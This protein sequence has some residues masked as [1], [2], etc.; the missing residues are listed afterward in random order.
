MSVSLISCAEQELDDMGSRISVSLSLEKHGFDNST[1]KTYL[2]GERVCWGTTSADK[3]VYVFDSNGA[4]NV[5]TRTSPVNTGPV[6][7]FVGTVTSGATPLYVLWSGK[8]QSYDQSIITGDVI[9]GTSLAVMNP[10]NISNTNSFANNA[11]ISVM[12]YNADCLQN[13]FGNI[14]S[15]TDV[16][17]PADNGSLQNVFGYIRYT[18]PQGTDGC[19][20]IKSVT[21]SA[22]E[23]LSGQ[24]QIDCSGSEPEV[25][26]IASPNTSLT[27]NT[28]YKS[29][30][31]YEAGTVYAVLPPGTYHNL[32]MTITPFV[33]GA[34]QQDASTGVPFTIEATEDVVV[35]RSKYTDAGTLPYENPNPN[36]E[37]PEDIWPNDTDAFDYGVIETKE[38]DISDAETYTLQTIDKVTYGAGLGFYTDKFAMNRVNEWETI[39][40]IQ[41]PKDS[42]ISFK[43]NK[44]GTLSFIPRVQ[45]VDTHPAIVVGLLTDSNG[46][47]S[48]RQIFNTTL[49]LTNTIKDEAARLTIPVSEEYMADITESA[50]VYV[51]SEQGSLLVYP[52][53]WSVD[54][55]STFNV[56]P[57]ASIMKTSVL[58]SENTIIPATYTKGNCYYISNSGNDDNTGLNSSSPIKTIAKL[59]TLPLS[60]GDAVLFKR[61]DMWRREVVDGSVMI[62]TK[63][64]VTYS[65]YGT[66]DKPI[67]NGSP[68]NGAV[69]GSWAVTSKANVY[70]YS[71]T[72]GAE[73]GGIF[74]NGTHESA[75]KRVSSTS[76]PFDW[77]DLSMDKDF[78]QQDG[79]IYFCSTVGNPTQRFTSMEFNVFGN[80]IEGTDNVT[81]DNLCLR[82][83]GSHGIN[84]WATEGMNIINCEIGLIGGAYWLG[85]PEGE[86]VRYGNGIQLYGSCG[87]FNVQNC[88]IYQCFD[89]GLTHQLSD[90]Q[91]MACVMENVKYRGNLIE[92]CTWSIEWFRYQLSGV[93]RIM[94]NVLIECNICR[95]A[96]YGW[97]QQRPDVDN[98][99]RHI[100]TWRADNPSDNFVIRNNIFECSTGELFQIHALQDE[101]LPVFESNNI[102]I[103]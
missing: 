70:V 102:C 3:V 38:A 45:N 1:T 24:I 22:D 9:S 8:S 32:K 76:M 92:N 55:S 64:G 78:F 77:T 93:E 15:E 101:W 6:A 18:I 43:I 68:Y 99:A 19:A 47:K 85:S 31:G 17:A 27:V 34:T 89:T 60:P 12:K 54:M 7:Q 29:G 62:P 71:H 30:L 49:Y 98:P 74:L 37:I 61:G 87:Y 96:G 48:Y 50:T 4:K 20:T 59:N 69:D 51:Y 14:T 66:G 13:V 53:K 72:F 58:S 42:Y 56:T 88:W 86:P 28:R 36:W 79:K 25:D 91:T 35:T 40:G 52:I 67:L 84:T 21:F 46:E 10:Q 2:S 26:I 33:S 73:V 82:H 103:N 44:P 95:W 83:S 81:I 57:E 41:L 94:H 80:L 16:D 23:P 100:K 39:D 75:F 63:D 97:G 11:N 65:S 5:F 90:N